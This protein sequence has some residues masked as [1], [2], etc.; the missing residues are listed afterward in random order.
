[1]NEEA[2]LYAGLQS[3]LGGGFCTVEDTEDMFWL[4]EADDYQSQVQ[5][6]NARAGQYRFREALDAY[7]NALKIRTDDWQL[8]Y[9]IG[10]ANL[11]LRRFK[12]AVEAYKNCRI[13]CKDE[14]KTAFPLGISEY[15][16]H[17]PAAAAAYFE[18]C[19]PDTGEM[20]IAVIYWHT[21]SCY[22][23]EMPPALLSQYDPERNVGHHTAYR[24]AVELFAGYITP[25][26]LD[27]RIKKDEN[28]LNTV[29]AFY[30]ISVYLEAQRR[31]TESNEY[32]REL[33]KYDSVWPC[34]P[35][36]A[37]WSDLQRREGC[38]EY[39]Y[40]WRLD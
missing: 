19:L 14:K 20:T 26:Q 17:N 16:Q 25:T 5:L 28:V 10:G 1:M 32:L 29:I 22:R 9:R 27:T 24:N 39:D 40:S 11:T 33:M 18:R 36:L 8:W 21:L 38:T 37:A 30:G 3:Q 23:A 4:R 12:E 13:R 31:N 34:I 6:G 2:S 7:Q 35:Y 15:L